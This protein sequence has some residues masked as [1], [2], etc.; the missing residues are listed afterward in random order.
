MSA[1]LNRDLRRVGEFL[2]Q[3][4]QAHFEPHMI[5]GHIDLTGRDLPQRADAKQHPVAAPRFFVDLQNRHVD[6][7]AAES[8]L[9]PATRFVAA[10]AMGNRY[11]KR[12]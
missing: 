4:R 8:G 7:C 11:D 10:E 5:F 3:P 6:R 12:S 2:Q 1:L 9:Q